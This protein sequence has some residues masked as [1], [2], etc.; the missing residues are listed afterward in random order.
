MLNRQE[1]IINCAQKLFNEKGYYSISVQDIIDA[2]GISKGTFYN[3]FHSKKDLVLA[4]LQHV[5]NEIAIERQFIAKTGSKKDK[6]LLKEQIAIK[7]RL[8]KKYRVFSLYEALV[9]ENNAD[10]KVLISD[11]RVKEVAWL[12]HRFIDVYGPEINDYA[13]DLATA[14]IGSL[15]QQIRVAEMIS[16]EKKSVDEF[17][18]FNLYY[19]ECALPAIKEKKKILFSE[20]S[21]KIVSEQYWDCPSNILERICTL[22]AVLLKD[23]ENEGPEMAEMLHFIQKELKEEQPRLHVVI[24]ITK[25]LTSTPDLPSDLSMLLLELLQFVHMYQKQKQRK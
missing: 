13:F 24:N 17:I 4:L 9:L 1:I 6:Q 8:F 3:Y 10:L 11:E 20:S 7:M 16:L 2:S 25:V 12:A 21:T 18:E 14:F 22:I 15:H 19:L 5:N 23:T